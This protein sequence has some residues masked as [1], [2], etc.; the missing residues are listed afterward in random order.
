MRRALR[1]RIGIILDPVHSQM[2][3]KSDCFLYKG[4][5]FPKSH[6]NTSMA[7]LLLSNRVHRQNQAHEQIPAL[8]VISRSPL[9]CNNNETRAPIAS[10]LN[11]AQ[12]G[13]TPYHSPNSSSYIQVR[14]AVRECGEG[15]TDI[16]TAVTTIRFVS[17]RTHAKC[18]RMYRTVNVQNHKL[19]RLSLLRR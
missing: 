12:L 5:P 17:S 2:M 10:P 15:Q 4:Y 19:G 14:A 3:A 6:A 11:S 16:Q 13:G 7:T 18:S 1:F 8:A 9:C